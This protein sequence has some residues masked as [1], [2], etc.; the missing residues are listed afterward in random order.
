MSKK[1]QGEFFKEL[2]DHGKLTALFGSMSDVFLYDKNSDSK[3]MMANDSTMKLWGVS[4]LEEFTGKTDHDYFDKSL[5]D[6]Y[7]V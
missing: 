4:S 5:A 1:L 3:F 7:V 2:A 6:L